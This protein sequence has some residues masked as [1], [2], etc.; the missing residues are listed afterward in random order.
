MNSQG[1]GAPLTIL[2]TGATDGIGRETARQLAV[3]GAQVVV[4]GRDIARVQA[5]RDELKGLTGR[6]QPAGVVFDLG[7]FAAIRQGAADLAAQLPRLDRLIHNAG[8]FAKTLDVDAVG[9]ERSWKINHL[10]PILLTHELLPVLLRSAPS[11]VVVVASVAHQRGQIHWNQLH[12][13]TGYTAYAQSKLAN[14]LFAQALAQRFDPSQLS[15]FSLHPGV[16]GTKLL[17]EGFGMDG[18][19]SLQEGAATSVHCALAPGLEAQTGQYFVRSR[20]VA[21]APQA[22]LAEDVDRLWQLSCAQVGVPTQ[23]H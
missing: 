5:V 8:V 9:L 11:R 14:I 2:V 15:A 16:V 17:R 18:N 1:L 10:S 3:H 4:H 7:D 19:D 21:P 23:W 13:Q 22:T 20:A 6:E 12:Q